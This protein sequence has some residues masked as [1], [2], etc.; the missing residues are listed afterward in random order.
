MKAELW[1]GLKEFV[2][3][4]LAGQS[5]ILKAELWLELKEFVCDLAEHSRALKAELWM[6]A[7]LGLKELMLGAMFRVQSDNQGPNPTLTTTRQ[8]II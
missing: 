3:C 2:V 1:L 6:D 4:D 5:W 8:G 7:V